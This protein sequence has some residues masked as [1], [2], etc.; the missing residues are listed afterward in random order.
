[1][2]NELNQYPKSFLQPS[3]IAEKTAAIIHPA[4]PT[5]SLIAALVFEGLTPVDVFDPLVEVAG[6]LEALVGLG[7]RETLLKV[8]VEAPGIGTVTDALGP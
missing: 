4:N 2:S 7:G 6:L 8:I 1:L 3:K 5:S